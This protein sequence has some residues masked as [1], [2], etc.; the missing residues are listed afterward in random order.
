MGDV[1]F[2]SI[3]DIKSAATTFRFGSIS[4]SDRLKQARRTGEGR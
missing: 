1:R 2:T 4:L 3:R